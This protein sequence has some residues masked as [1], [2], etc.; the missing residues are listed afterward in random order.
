MTTNIN[1][2]SQDEIVNIA[3]DAYTYG[4][5]L[6]MMDL[7]R[8]VQTNL[9]IPSGG[10]APMNQVGR[11]QTFPTYQTTEVVKPNVDTLYN[12]VWFDL[13][14]DAFVVNMPYSGIE[15]YTN[16]DELTHEELLRGRYYLL[17]F[18]DAYSNVHV[19][20][21]T[22]HT[23]KESHLFL[24]TGPN[25]SGSVPVNMHH[26]PM[27]T[28]MV[29]ML[30]RIQANNDDDASQ[31]VWPL[32]QQLKCTPYSEW[33]NPA[34]VPPSG[35]YNAAM[36]GVKPVEYVFTLDY[37]TFIN[38]MLNL[39]SINPPPIDQDRDILERMKSIGIEVGNDFDISKF[40]PE[41]ILRIK[42]IP[43]TIALEWQL[44]ILPI[45]EDQ[46]EIQNNWV[47]I[48]RDIGRFKNN[49]LNR[50]FIAYKGLGANIIEDAVYP[51]CEKDI[52]GNHLMGGKKYIISMTEDELPP[53]NAFWSLTAYNQNDFLVHNTNA[54]VPIYSVGSREGLNKSEDQ[55]YHILVQNEKPDDPD[56]NW[57]P[58]PSEGLMSLSLRIYWPKS[59]VLE[60]TWSPPPVVLNA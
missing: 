29:W 25:W 38:D 49:Y 24:V 17:P 42:E 21:G 9:V 26:I 5:P 8:Q 19:S 10:H 60:G 27:P 6:V 48:I 56:A 14:Q 57:L 41:T 45:L 20:K 28:P 52:E 47:N 16:K 34:Y 15:S 43:R 58:S 54:Q 51:V 46:G 30:G 37:E 22:R 39:M 31:V 59:N 3:K 55:K 23:E 33:D 50:A 4:F 11:A 18:L 2:L 53:M 13:N 35:E 40:S 36:D 44:K 12:I 1:D 7:T 32:Q